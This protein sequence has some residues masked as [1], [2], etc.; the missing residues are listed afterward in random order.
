MG[1]WGKKQ[2][3]YRKGVT[4]QPQVQINL[5]CHNIVVC[6]IVQYCCMS[7]AGLL[8]YNSYNKGCHLERIYH[9]ICQIINN[10]TAD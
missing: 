6:S 8:A 4:K 5:F 7:D 9:V 1:G 3:V 10:Y 2:A